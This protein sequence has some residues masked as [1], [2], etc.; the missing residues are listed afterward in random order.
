[1]QTI[2]ILNCV[3]TNFWKMELSTNYSLKNHMNNDVT[4]CKQMTGVRLNC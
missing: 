1:M 2:G 4:V 3:Q